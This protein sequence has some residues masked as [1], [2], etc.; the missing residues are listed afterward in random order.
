M[1][2]PLVSILIPVYNCRAWLANAIR[3]ALNQTWPEKEVVVLDDGSTDGGHE[4]IQD[5]A[6]QVRIYRQPNRG[7]NASRNQLTTLSRGEWL[8][9]LD[10]DDELA[11]DNVAEKMK[12]VAEAEAVYGTMELATFRGQE[13]IDSST[14]IA[15]DYYDGW[16]AAFHWK[17]PNTSSFLFNRQALFQTGGWNE[18]IKN[19]TDY[20]LLF[21]MLLNS[22]R[23]RAAPKAISIYRQWS[24]TQA[25]NEAPMRKMRTRLE[26][27][28]RA[29]ESLRIGGEMTA[30]RRQAFLNAALGV[31]RTI[32]TVDCRIAIEEHRRLTNWEPTFRPSPSVFPRRYV[33]V[34]NRFGFSLT[35]RLATL[36]RALKP[37]RKRQLI[38]TSILVQAREAVAP[39]GS[40]G[41]L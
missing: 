2:T 36:V 32:Y 28:W 24:V 3:S 22:H 41:K 4:L 21:R 10:A 12:L 17:F 5:F 30:E 31:I 35:E 40:I 6:G 26:L 11:P 14:I 7:Q 1:T 37:F 19:C 29:V 8:V 33:G 16:V 23:F 25:V 20:D 27:M 18:R 39:G 9:Y 15:R 13:K 38:D 34:Y